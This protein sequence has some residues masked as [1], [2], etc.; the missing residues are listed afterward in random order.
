MDFDKLLFDGGI[1][2]VGTLKTRQEK[3]TIKKYSE[4]VFLRSKW[5]IHGINSDGDFCYVMLKT[6][7]FY[8]SKN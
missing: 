1:M 7:C 6:V 2:H 4:R 8:L 3:Y 5:F